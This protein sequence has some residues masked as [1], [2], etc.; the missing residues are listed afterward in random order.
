MAVIKEVNISGGKEMI[1]PLTLNN[2]V[3]GRLL[4]RLVPQECLK[5][6]CAWWEDTSKECAIKTLGQC[7]VGAVVYLHNI[8]ELMPTPER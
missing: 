8:V 3:K 2:Q 1:C 4:F 7:I 5:E 6:E